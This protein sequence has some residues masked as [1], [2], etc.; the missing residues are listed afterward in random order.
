MAAFRCISKYIVSMYFTI[1]FLRKDF[2]FIFLLIVSQLDYDSYF[3]D[4]SRSF[5]FPMNK[6]VLQSIKLWKSR[7]NYFIFWICA[8]FDAAIPNTGTYFDLWP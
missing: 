4:N 1:P 2:S 5:N 6:S 8:I 3:S 7:L